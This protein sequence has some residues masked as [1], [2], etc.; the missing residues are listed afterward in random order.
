[1]QPARSFC[2][3]SCGCIFDVMEDII[4]TGIDAKH[5]NE[6]QI[7]PFD[8]WIDS[9]NSR[10]G[11]LGGI[12]LNTLCLKKYD[13]V[14]SEVLDKGTRFRSR[15]RGYGIGSGNSIPEYVPEEGFRAM[16]EAVKEIRRRETKL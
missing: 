1:M 9:Y 6:D 4:A 16:I 12:D 13:E 7:A 10:I 3:H 15:A 11:L 5:S 8:K 14:Y 2:L